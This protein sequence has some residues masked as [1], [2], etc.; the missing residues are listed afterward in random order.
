MPEVDQCIEV[1][2]RECGAR[3]G[4][5]VV[6]G[7]GVGNRVP[8]GQAV[9][10]EAEDAVLAAVADIEQAT[11]P[12]LGE[13]QLHMEANAAVNGALNVAVRRRRRRGRSRSRP[14]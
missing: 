8:L 14:R 1:F 6:T 13:G 3:F 5:R 7:V 2:V 11:V 4:A 9:V 12:V 10:G